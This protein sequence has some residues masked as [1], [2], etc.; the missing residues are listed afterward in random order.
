MVLDLRLE[1]ID[2]REISNPLFFANIHSIFVP[3]ISF[4]EKTIKFSKDI[5]SSPH[6][7]SK[8][9]THYNI[10]ELYNNHFNPN[11]ALK[12]SWILIFLGEQMLLVV[13][14]NNSGQ[15]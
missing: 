5:F 15:F 8:K 7:N 10:G 4:F 1:R 9:T 2:C 13:L 6:I 11:Q 3:H 12:L 14:A